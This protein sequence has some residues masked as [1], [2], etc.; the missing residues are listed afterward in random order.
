VRRDVDTLADLRT[1][2]SLGVGPATEK[3]LASLEI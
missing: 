2:V 3:A 1:A